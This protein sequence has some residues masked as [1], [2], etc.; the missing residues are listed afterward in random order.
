MIQMDKISFDENQSTAIPFFFPYQLKM[1]EQ[2]PQKEIYLKLVSP[3]YS[4]CKV[5]FS[6]EKEGK[7]FVKYQTE[8]VID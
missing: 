6:K 3:H 2:I 4:G 8:E 7:P 1:R 5:S